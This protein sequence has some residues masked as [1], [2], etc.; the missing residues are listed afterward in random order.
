MEGQGQACR[1]HRLYTVH[2]CVYIS[3]IQYTLGCTT[4]TV[5]QFVQSCTQ[6]VHIVV[7]ISCV[8]NQIYGMLGGNL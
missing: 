7:Y 5:T 3:C 2:I 8:Y 6:F 1:L 4:G